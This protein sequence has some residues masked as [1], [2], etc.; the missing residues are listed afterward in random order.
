MLMSKLISRIS[1]H[2]FKSIKEASIDLSGL[3]ILV[4]EN[5]AGKSSLLQAIFL[6]AEI[7]SGTGDSRYVS[8]NGSELR[9]GSFREVL[10]GGLREDDLLGI[11]LWVPQRR[12]MSYRRSQAVTQGRAI[13]EGRRDSRTA[14]NSWRLELAA[15]PSEQVGIAQIAGATIRSNIEFDGDEIIDWG[16]LRVEPSEPDKLMQKAWT[17]GQRLGLMRNFRVGRKLRFME[18]GELPPFKAEAIS[19]LRDPDGTLGEEIHWDSPAVAVSNGIPSQAFRLGGSQD[20]AT[21]WV[22]RLI[23]RS[24]NRS[25]TSPYREEIAYDDENHDWSEIS[26]LHIGEF[27]FPWFKEWAES[28]N[29]QEHE[30]AVRPRNFPVL[31]QDNIQRIREIWLEIINVLSD[32]LNQKLGEFRILVPSGEDGD[33]TD[34]GSAIEAALTGTVHY[35]GP[36][37][38]GPLTFYQGGQQGRIATLGMNGELTISA[39]HNRRNESVEYRLE[40]GSPVN[41]TLGEALDYWLKKFSLAGSITTK[42]QGKAGIT[43]ELADWQSGQALDLGNVGVGISQIL[44][45]LVLCLLAKRGEIILLEQP[46]LHLH[47]APQQI[48]GDFLIE[49]MGLG[50]QLVV[51]T[52]SEYLVNRLRLRLAEDETDH[53]K[54]DIDIY[55]AVR[56]DGSTQFSPMSI[57]EFGGFEEWPDGFFDQTSTESEEILRVAVRR[58]REK[59]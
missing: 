43:V 17:R 56:Q 35:L 12:R 27:C 19:Y 28:S 57:D 55:Y 39:L 20:I 41:A 51:E 16:M 18:E 15:G 6:M 52:H 44:P 7:V 10:Y 38:V 54:D 30:S 48:L 23:R 53:L 9:L 11:E 40:S 31:S 8:L 36:L 21:A 24:E 22:E 50:R 42:E 4:G 29:A 13:N 49:M 5:S 46:E 25:R 32:M 14:E 3:T 47:P 26:A 37:R 34:T 45:V 2:Q 1:I 59:K 58:R 33:E